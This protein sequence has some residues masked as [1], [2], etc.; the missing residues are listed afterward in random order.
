M[1]SLADFRAKVQNTIKGTPSSGSMAD[2]L[3]APS[4]SSGYV[5]DYA[6]NRPTDRKAIMSFQKENGLT[7]DGV[8]GD[9]TQAAWDRTHQGVN[10]I[11]S[12]VRTLPAGL[13]DSE[14][15]TY[16]YSNSDLSNNS[17]RE[18]AESWYR[19]LY[20]LPKPEEAKPAPLSETIDGMTGGMKEGEFRQ[21]LKGLGYE[22]GDISDG[23]KM[24]SDAYSYDTSKLSPQARILAREAPQEGAPQEQRDIWNKLLA[25]AIKGDTFSDNDK[26]FLLAVAEGWGNRYGL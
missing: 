13:S 20:G 26:K 8:W 11:D 24:Y 16:I 25:D 14:L 12:W 18:A 19:E 3:P 5:S 9:Q 23:W 1:S 21:H 4:E 17:S 6:A 2:I 15:A 7:A 10:S 22:T